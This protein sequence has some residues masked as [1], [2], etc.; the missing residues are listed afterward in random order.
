MPVHYFIV[1]GPEEGDFGIRIFECENRDS[2]N[3]E[4][5]LCQNENLSFD[6]MNFSFAYKQKQYNLFKVSDIAITSILS[7][8]PKFMK[9]EI[10]QE[11]TILRSMV[12]RNIRDELPIVLKQL[13]QLY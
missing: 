9:V 12:Y 5:T 1:V 10:P 6:S 2:S 7:H 4:V 8:G 3:N 11:F 13:S